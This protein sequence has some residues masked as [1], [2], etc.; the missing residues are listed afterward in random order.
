MN[1]RLTISFTKKSASEAAVAVIL[2]SLLVLMVNPFN[3]FMPSMLQLMTAGIAVVVFGLF[4]TFVLRE[5]AA[6]ER[7]EK[8][9][10]LAGRIAFLT[11]SA[12][13]LVGIVIQVYREMLDTWLVLSLVVMIVAKIVTRMYS[14]ENL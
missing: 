14:E 13:L 6:D 3:I 10:S 8:H 7:E 4:S 5:D 1:N 12:V 9:R 11:G 2:I